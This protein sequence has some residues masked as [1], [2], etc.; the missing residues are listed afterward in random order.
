MGRHRLEEPTDRRKSDEESRIYKLIKSAH[1]AGLRGEGSGFYD[2]YAMSEEF[3]RGE[4]S[5]F[6]IR[7]TH[8][9]NRLQQKRIVKEVKKKGDNMADL[10]ELYKMSL[11]MEAPVNF[12]QYM[13]YMEFDRDPKDKFYQPRRKQL[14]PFVD[15]IQQIEDGTLDEILLSCPPR[16]GKTTLFDFFLTWEVGKHP[17][18]SNLYSSCSDTV[19][20]VFYNG[21]IEIMKDD[22]TYHW[23]KVFP[24]SPIV[25]VNADT[26]TINCVRNNKY[27]SITCRSIDGTLNGACDCDNILIGDDLCKGIE[28]AINKDVMGRLWQKVQNDF[29]TRAKQS[30]KK[31]W[32]GTRWSLIDPI[33]IRKEMLMN[34]PNF[35]S[36]RWKEINIPALNE[37]NESNFDYAYGVGFDSEEYKRVRAGFERNDD[38]ASWSAQ[39]MGQPIEREGSLFASGDMRFYNGV[40][41]EIEP[42]RVFMA[43]DPAWGGKDYCAGPVCV[44]YGD[45]VYVPDVVYTNEDKRKSIPDI[46]ELIRKY[47]IRTVQIEANKMTEGYADELRDHLHN[48]G[49]KCT[50]TTKPA[51][52]RSGQ[53]KEDRIVDRSPEIRN[54]FIF[55]ESGLRSKRYESFMNN[56]FSFTIVGKNTHDDAP[57]SMAMAADMVFK[58]GAT[59]ASVFARFI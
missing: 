23:D 58:R 11:K 25:K 44:Q 7:M 20:K 36:V 5:D 32:I 53:S 19:T 31:I 51:P 27:P 17:L 10:I 49:I 24:E 43:I 8:D 30:A 55:L 21:L 38:M 47:S 35:K 40:L 59:H 3:L 50:I 54:N 28:Q 52:S 18:R 9:M 42:N 1:E 39:Y 57:D 34:D 15:A 26:Q 14:K 4:A 45:D 41:P 22:F 33:G 16:I 46:A 37:K 48:K 12:D 13:L 2:F 29:L 6:H 56:M